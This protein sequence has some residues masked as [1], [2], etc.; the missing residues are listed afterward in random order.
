MKFFAQHGFW[1]ALGPIL[2]LHLLFPGDIP[3]LC[4]EPQLIDN[5]L[6]ANAAGTLAER[7]LLGTVGV[8][9]GP[10]AT[11]GYQALLAITDNL[12]AIS[13]IKQLISLALILSTLLFMAQRLALPR[14]P[15]LIV[16]LS[17]QIHTYLRQLWDNV[18]LI[19]LSV[20][21]LALALQFLHQPRRR[22]IVAMTAVVVLLGHIHLMTGILILPIACVLCWQRRDWL[23]KN[24]RPTAATQAIGLALSAPYLVGVCQAFGQASQAHASRLDALLHAT[25]G[26]SYFSFLYTTHSF[27]SLG[28]SHFV[29]APT[30]TA[31]LSW[32]SALVIP[33]FFIGI[34]R[35]LRSSQ[36]DLQRSLAWICLGIVG[37]TLLFHG[38]GAH[39]FLPHY[40]NGQWFGF[41]FFIWIGAAW[42]TK[43]RLGQIASGAVVASLLLLLTATKLHVHANQGNQSLAFGTTLSHQLELADQLADYPRSTQLFIAPGPMG[44]CA[45]SIRLL[46][47]M[48]DREPTQSA[49]ALYLYYQNTIS[50]TMVLAEKPPGGN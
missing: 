33:I 5:A 49:P 46:R 25:C 22:W 28:K 30:L 7:G 18:F 34:F 16:L 40:L 27:P 11:W 39:I 45:V 29:L 10:Q 15:I 43:Y 14:W 26:A 47:A 35:A 32:L 1:L 23:L 8:H 17:P 41:F 48:Q 13:V 38:G 19:P 20:V 2:V 42:I 4:D 21:L 12:I 9:Y 37:L 6:Q 36:P 31:S 24:W 3:F 50:G 44:T